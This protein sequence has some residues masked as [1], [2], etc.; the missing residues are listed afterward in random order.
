MNLQSPQI[1]ASPVVITNL[2]PL[3]P[4]LSQSDFGGSQSLVPLGII[5][6]A[7]V[8]RLREH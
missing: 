2:G 3:M 5:S 8:G 7:T 4:S 1:H 6:A